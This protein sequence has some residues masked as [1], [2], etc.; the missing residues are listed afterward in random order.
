MNS[1]IAL[2][3]PGWCLYFPPL[4]NY[5]HSYIYVQCGFF[6]WEF[7]CEKSSIPPQFQRLI[8]QVIEAQSNNCFLWVSKISFQYLSTLRFVLNNLQL[9]WWLCLYRFSLSV[10]SFLSCDWI[11]KIPIMM[12]IERIFI[13]HAYWVLCASCTWIVSYFPRLRTFSI[14][15][16]NNL[17]LL[18]FGLFL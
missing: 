18:I 9:F 5:S 12:W 2:F 11:S 13:D 1:V 4:C 14:I 6:D 7:L 3:F 8:F 10:F 16:V 15:S 17:W